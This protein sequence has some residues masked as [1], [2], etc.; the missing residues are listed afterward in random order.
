MV[1]KLKN[2]IGKAFKTASSMMQDCGDGYGSAWIQ[3]DIRT[4]LWMCEGCGLVWTRQWQAETCADGTYPI[5]NANGFGKTYDRDH[6][7]SF[8]Q[9]YVMKYTGKKYAYIRTA[10]GRMVNGKLQ[11]I[12]PVAQYLGGDE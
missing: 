11:P 8:P 6:C 9:W 4:N 5:F 1:T 12:K 7:E 3:K 2:S 10:F